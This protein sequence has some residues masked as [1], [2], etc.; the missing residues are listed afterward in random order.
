M[1]DLNSM[2]FKAPGDLSQ[3]KNMVPLGVIKRHMTREER[4]KAAERA[5]AQKDGSIEPDLD[6][7]GKESTPMSLNLLPMRHGT[8]RM[9]PVG[10]PL[11]AIK[12][13]S[14]FLDF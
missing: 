7:D 11:F 3:D 1:A 6:V 2:E 9:I 14:P 4:R 10:K 12:S 13:S 8:H 5:E